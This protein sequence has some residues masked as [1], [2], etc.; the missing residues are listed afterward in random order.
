MALPDV[1]AAAKGKA[2]DPDR[3]LAEERL[4]GV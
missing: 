2:I 1:L 4:V 3:S